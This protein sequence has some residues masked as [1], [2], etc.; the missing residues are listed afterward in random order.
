MQQVN[1]GWRESEVCFDNRKKRA[2]WGLGVGGCGLGVGESRR[3]ADHR[4]IPVTLFLLL[5]TRLGLLGNYSHATSLTAGS[6]SARVLTI[7]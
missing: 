5:V 6:A 2:G 4:H 1:E 7:L 3:L